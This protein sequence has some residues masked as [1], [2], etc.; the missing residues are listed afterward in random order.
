M[1]WRHDD[2][3]F[4]EPTDPQLRA[5]ATMTREQY[6]HASDCVDICM[7]IGYRRCADGA[8]DEG[9]A[10]GRHGRSHRVAARY[11]RMKRRATL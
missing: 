1:T 2:Y 3:R 7:T 11:L 8:C 6:A 5:Y 10:C 9:G 4:A